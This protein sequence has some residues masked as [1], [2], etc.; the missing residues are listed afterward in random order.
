MFPPGVTS[1]IWSTLP[2]ARTST[3][4]TR[5][6]PTGTTWSALILDQHGLASQVAGHMDGVTRRNAR[7]VNNTFE[8]LTRYQIGV[9]RHG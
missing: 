3:S 7:Q 5:V 2:G 8:V 9:G 4:F 1:S 6:S